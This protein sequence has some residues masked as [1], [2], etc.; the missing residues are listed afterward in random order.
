VAKLTHFAI[1]HSKRKRFGTICPEV[2][3]GKASPLVLLGGADTHN[4]VVAEI[5]IADNPNTIFVVLISWNPIIPLGPKKLETFG[6]I[7]TSNYLPQR[8]V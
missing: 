3:K 2:E 8:T 1:Q 6:L 7:V 5:L 4:L